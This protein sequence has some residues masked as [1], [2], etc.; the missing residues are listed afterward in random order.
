MKVFT[1]ISVYAGETNTHARV[2]LYEMSTYKSCW[3]W[4]VSQF[5]TCMSL[6]R[7]GCQ[8][9]SFWKSDSQMY[10]IPDQMN[11]QF[12]Q[13]LIYVFPIPLKTSCN[14]HR[15]RKAK[16]F[17]AFCSGKI[18]LVLFQGCCSFVL[19]HL[20]PV[21][22]YYMNWSWMQSTEWI[23]LIGNPISACRLISGNNILLMEYV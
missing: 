6:L 7:H 17:S 4:S 5:S 21:P 22:I 15:W 8:R 20:C 23:D 13:I 10:T 19:R 1:F 9:N 12:V 16:V 3:S 18:C 14:R 2:N 11:W